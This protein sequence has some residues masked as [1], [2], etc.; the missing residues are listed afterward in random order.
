MMIKIYEYTIQKI[1]INKCKL[2]K[3]FVTNKQIEKKKL[4]NDYYN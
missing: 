4:L 2:E 3:M 1:F